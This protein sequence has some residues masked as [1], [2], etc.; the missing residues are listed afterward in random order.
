MIRQLFNARRRKI[1]IDV[2]TQRDFFLADGK[3]CT[4]NH[5][6]ILEHI[7]RVMAWARYKNIPIISTCEIYPNN[8]GGSAVNYCLDGTEGQ[9]KI[10]YTLMNNR[11][12]FAADNRMDLPSDVLRRYRQIILYKRSIDPF[13]E[14]RIERLLSEVRANEFILIGAIAEGAVMAMALGLLQRNKKVTV[15]VDAIGSVNKRE[16]K[17]AFRKMKAKGAKLIE[18]RKFAGT[19]RLRLVGACN[20]K[21][22]RGRLEKAAIGIESEN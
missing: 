10:G 22:C 9:Q 1:L 21:T 15:V 19:S 18:T 13:E 8:N 6:R 20:C 2:N 11:I 16:A 12:S 3:A 17:L 5:R 14:P 4:R 7:R